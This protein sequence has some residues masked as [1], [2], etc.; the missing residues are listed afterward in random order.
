MLVPFIEPE[1]LMADISTEPYKAIYDDNRTGDVEQ[2]HQT[3]GVLNTI[4][5]AHSW[6]V[7]AL[8]AIYVTI[9]DGSDDETSDLLKSAESQY[10]QYLAWCRKPKY[11]RDNGRTKDRDRCLELANT[12]MAKI[13]AN[14]LRI[15]P[16]DAQPEVKPRNAGGLIVSSAQ[17]V[18]LPGADGTTNSGDF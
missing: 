9:P 11:T 15:A 18:M 13:Q 8:P 14:I 6:V 16:K 1:D 5:Y 2:V 10:A 3:A 12:I 7:S 17:R 4:K